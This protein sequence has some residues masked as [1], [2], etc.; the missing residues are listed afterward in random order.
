MPILGHLPKRL[1]FRDAGPPCRY[2]TRRRVAPEMLRSSR[3]CRREPLDRIYG[4]SGSFDRPQQCW[5]LAHE[6]RATKGVFAIAPSTPCLL[7]WGLMCSQLDRGEKDFGSNGDTNAPKQMD[8]VAKVPACDFQRNTIENSE[9]AL[10]SVPVSRLAALGLQVH[11]RMAGVFLVL[12]GFGKEAI[13]VVSVGSRE[14]VFDAPD[15]PQHQVAVGRLVAKQL[16]H[17]LRRFGGSTSG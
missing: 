1:L 3:T 6:P 13:H 4:T 10:W 7:Q 5:F 16:F 15:F 2:P 14:R 12:A 9:S 17:I 8:S 11:D